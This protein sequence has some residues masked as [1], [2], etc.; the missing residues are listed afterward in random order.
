[1]AGMAS[2]AVR[3]G[4]P[5]A[6]AVLASQRSRASLV[7]SSRVTVM[8]CT[9]IPGPGAGDQAR[10]RGRAGD[11]GFDHGVDGLACVQARD[12]CR[13]GRG[14]D[15]AGQRRVFAGAEFGAGLRHDLPPWS[16]IR[17]RPRRQARAGVEFPASAGAS[18]R[19]RYP[20]LSRDHL[21]RLRAGC[22]R[23]FRAASD[24]RGSD[25]SPPCAPL[26]P[27]HSGAATR[28][29]RAERTD[30]AVRPPAQ[31]CPDH[32]RGALSSRSLLGIAGADRSARPR[33]DRLTSRPGC[34]TRRMP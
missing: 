7:L 1:M 27:V 30:S 3:G 24:R 25:A 12:A 34:Q 22:Q 10:C 15:P 14:T 4:G 8:S 19:R 31:C 28:G 17:T 16:Q 29:L 32:D 13:D 2:S 33:R 18:G 23:G 9:A 26:V 6:A 11:R 20:A 21:R 5:V